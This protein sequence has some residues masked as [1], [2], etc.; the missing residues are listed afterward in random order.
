ME[1]MGNHKGI[2]VT[3]MPGGAST[4]SDP[5]GYFSI[6]GLYTAIYTVTAVVPYR[7][8]RINRPRRV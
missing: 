6:D 3:A 4:Y 2:L 5:S 7:A 1:G 8:I